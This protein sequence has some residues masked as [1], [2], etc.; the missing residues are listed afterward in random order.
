MERP[1]HFG[2]AIAPGGT[3]PPSALSRHGPPQAKDW[4]PLHAVTRPPCAS[5][6][7][8][9]TARPMPPGD[10]LQISSSVPDAGGRTGLVVVAAQA[11]RGPRFD[12]QASSAPCAVY[13]H[14]NNTTTQSKCAAFCKAAGRRQT[15]V[16]LG[17]PL[18]AGV[19]LQGRP[20]E[21]TGWRSS[22]PASRRCHRRRQAPDRARLRRTS[23]HGEF[24]VTNSTTAT[25]GR[26]PSAKRT[27]QAAADRGL[28]GT[29]DGK[30]ERTDRRQD[31]R[32]GRLLEALRVP[33]LSRL[34]DAQPCGWGTCVASR[35]RAGR[36]PGRRQRPAEP[37]PVPGRDALRGLRSMAAVVAFHASQSARLG[38]A[39]ATGRVDARY[40]VRAAGTHVPAGAFRP[41]RG[42]A[43]GSIDRPRGPDGFRNLGAHASTARALGQ[44]SPGG[45][46]Q[47]HRPDPPAD[48]MAG[49]AG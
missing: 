13:S 25:D 4:L 29:P 35:Q 32:T 46:D 8:R 48:T 2:A 40:D 38:R 31:C 36:G 37:D 9:R 42:R 26:S 47:R 1:S 19:S 28:S 27:H 20:Q 16:A 14:G 41:V 5:L 45:M 11:D 17:A 23:Y 30:S 33:A 24:P 10:R 12:T 39:A 49:T 44:G 3:G 21:A 18:P 34:A 22:R 7:G 6:R 15:G 43:P